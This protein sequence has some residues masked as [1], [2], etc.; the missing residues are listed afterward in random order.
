MG[1]SMYKFGHNWVNAIFVSIPDLDQKG[2]FVMSIHLIWV[3]AAIV[4]LHEGTR[5]L[6]WEGRTCIRFQLFLIVR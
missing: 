4:H 1:E 3:Y 6:Q 2:F 5:V